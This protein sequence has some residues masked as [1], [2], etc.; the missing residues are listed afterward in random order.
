MNGNNENENKC[1]IIETPQKT[2]VNK[3]VSLSN[4]HNNL[5]MYVILIYTTHWIYP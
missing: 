1:P 3:Q 5:L 2:T 4:H